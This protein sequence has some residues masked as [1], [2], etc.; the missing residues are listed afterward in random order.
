M[1]LL[2]IQEEQLPSSSETSDICTYWPANPTFDLKWV[3][4]RRMFFINEKKT[5]YMTVGFYSA[6]D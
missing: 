4:L 6:R 1:L 3:L 5:K 2:S